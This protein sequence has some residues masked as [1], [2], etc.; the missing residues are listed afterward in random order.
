[1]ICFGPLDEVYEQAR[2]WLYHTLIVTMD[3]NQQ[4]QRAADAAL[5]YI[6][7]GDVIGVGTGS[8]TNFFIDALPRVKS[9]LDGA[10]AS[11]EISAERLRGLGI[12]VLDLNRTGD[13][14]LYVDGAD[15]AT[16]TLYLIKG[17]GARINEQVMASETTSVTLADISDEGV[18]KIS[19]GKK[20][21]ALISVED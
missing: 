2:I 3:Q 7:S 8:T 10:V 19:A 17:G 18:I 6:E 14:P 16:R 13:L 5:E 1:M 21:H 4:K 20:R 15:E 9:K 11:S 12:P